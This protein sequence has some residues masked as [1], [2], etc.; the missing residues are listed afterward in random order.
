MTYKCRCGISVNL[1]V[2]LQRRYVYQCDCGQRVELLRTKA[3][4]LMRSIREPEPTV[5]V[6]LCTVCGMPLACPD[7]LRLLEETDV[8]CPIC[9]QVSQV[10]DELREHVRYCSKQ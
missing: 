2:K 4:H 1:N 7:E 10:T 5:L 8:S 6:V 3:G 9:R